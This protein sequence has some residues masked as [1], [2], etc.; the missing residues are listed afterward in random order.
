MNAQELYDAVKH[1]PS[2]AWPE[3]A[4]CKDAPAVA[5]AFA[6]K[7]FVWTESMGQPGTELVVDAYA[8]VMF[9]GSLSRWLDRHE[10]HYTISTSNDGF[11]V[12]SA[13]MG[14]EAKLLGRGKTK[15]DALAAAVKTVGGGS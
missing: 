5:Y 14:T 3:S 15:V 11:S 2:K 7:R 1:S 8:E 9:D 6:F 10:N 12:Y 4:L 13:C